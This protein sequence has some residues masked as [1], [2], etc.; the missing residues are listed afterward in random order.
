MYSGAKIMMQKLGVMQLDGVILAGAFG[1]YIDKMSAAVIGLFPDCDPAHVRAVGNAAGDGARM[2]LLNIA[3]REEADVRARQVEYVEL[4]VA[5]D[6][7]R[8]FTQ[9]LAF[10]HQEDRFPHL[11]HLLPG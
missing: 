7:N 4:T 10:P 2:A 8:T 11:K 9:A 1:S 3:K 5:P 6:F